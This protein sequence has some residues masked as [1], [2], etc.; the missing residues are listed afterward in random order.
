MPH[1]K[2]VIWIDSKSNFS[3]NVRRYPILGAMSY[4]K[5]IILIGALYASFPL[6]DAGDWW[7]IPAVWGVALFLAYGGGANRTYT[8][9]EYVINWAKFA[10]H[11]GRNDLNSKNEY[12]AFTTAPQQPSTNGER[13]T[14]FDWFFGGIRNSIRGIS[15]RRPL[16]HSSRQSS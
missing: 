5:M 15:L 13:E 11:G 6:N 8:P 4:K 2:G 16:S 10:I 1:I 12:D 7:A 14:F 3:R 9:L